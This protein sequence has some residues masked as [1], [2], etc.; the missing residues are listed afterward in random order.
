MK[1]ESI[2]IQKWAGGQT[3]SRIWQN[4]EGDWRMIGWQRADGARAI[5]TNGDPAFEHE[6]GFEEAW[7]ECAGG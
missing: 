1:T 7:K 2:G 5:E 4:G 6:P 3:I